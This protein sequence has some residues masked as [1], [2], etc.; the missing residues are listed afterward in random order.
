VGY[1][2]RNTIPKMTENAWE[3]NDFQ[4]HFDWRVFAFTAGVTIVTGLLFGMA[5]ALA[6]AR[7]EVTHGLK[8]T[9]QTTT[10]RRKGMGGKAL[11]GFQIALSTL[12]VIGA[13]LFLRTLAALSKVDVGFRTD[14]L[15]LVEINPPVKA[16]PAG[17]DVRCISELEQAFAAVPGVDSVAP[18]CLMR[19]SPTIGT[20]QFLP[21]GVVRSE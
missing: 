9:A 20:G 8:E 13:G 16:Y 15:L 11:V 3:R 2:G 1:L 14:H 7:A 12:L 17:K 10:R 18:A 19:T 5:P 21:Q 4:I 6:A